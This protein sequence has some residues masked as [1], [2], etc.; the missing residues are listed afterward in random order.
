[1]TNAQTTVER[2]K[3]ANAVP[4]TDS[5]PPGALSSTALR[6]RIEERSTAMSNVLTYDRHT[7]PTEPP[8][9]GRGPLVALAVAAAVV[10]I[11][12]ITALNVLSRGTEVDPAIQPTQIVPSPEER[13]ARALPADTPLLTVVSAFQARWDAGDV[14]GYEALFHPDNGYVSGSDATTSWFVEATGTTT[15]RDCVVLET[16]QVSCT[17]RGI[18]R[19][20]P[21]TVTNT[22]TTLWTG[23]EG[24]IYTIEF[25]DGMPTPV[26]TNP[27]D[28]PGVAEYRSWLEERF[29][30]AFGTLFVD[31][32]TMTL[33]TEDVRTN[34]QGFVDMYVAT[35][36]PRSDRALAIETPL[37]ETVATFRD[38]FDTG[39]VEGYE[40]IFHPMAGYRSG[41]DAMASWFSEVTGTTAEHDCVL[42]SFTRLECTERAIAGLEPGTISD[43]YITV[44]NGADGYIWSI[45]F[46]EGAPPAFTDPMESPGV[47]AYRDWVQTNAPEQFDTLFPDGTTMD[48][49]SAELRAGHSAMV[50]RYR[51]AIGNA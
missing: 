10:L 31:G 11:L 24:Y 15:E 6:I 35:I 8:R 25:P 5:F 38:R 9:K 44:W 16:T 49:A 34:H 19:L 22:Y 30:D 37:L 12:G 50:E 27:T 1:M 3:S 2:I 39:D 26:L 17:E 21:G 4:S 33:D 43:P 48:L 14:A 42:V 40:A 28:G 7:E 29:P 18:S 36:D 13:G 32:M 20:Q 23:A 41:T 47:A 46:P 45:E 51:V